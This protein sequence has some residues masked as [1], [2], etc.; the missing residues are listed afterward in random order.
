V[1]VAGA[2]HTAAETTAGGVGQIFS[3]A[4]RAAEIDKKIGNPN[5]KS[6]EPKEQQQMEFGIPK[7][8][9]VD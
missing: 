8:K 5:P 3:A 6:F 4:S 9:F 2:M 7:N 1:A